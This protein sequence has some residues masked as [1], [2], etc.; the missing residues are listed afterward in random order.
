[1]ALA[2]RMPFASASAVLRAPRPIAFGGLS[3]EGAFPL[4]GGQGDPLRRGGQARV[5]VLVDC[6]TFE[7]YRLPVLVFLQQMHGRIVYRPHR[8]ERDH[9]AVGGQRASRRDLLVHA[10]VRAAGPR[11]RIVRLGFQIGRASCRERVLM[12]V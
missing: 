1:M 11:S 9:I 8:R 5:R 7:L 3:S 10:L 2:E 6:F 12:P 4:P